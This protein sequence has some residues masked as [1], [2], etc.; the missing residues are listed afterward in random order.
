MMAALFALFWCCC[1]WSWKWPGVEKY[2]TKCPM[3]FF[4]YVESHFAEDRRRTTSHDDRPSLARSSLI[5]CLLLLLS[6]DS[7]VQQGEEYLWW[8]RRAHVWL[9]SDSGKNV[10]R[11]EDHF[12]RHVQSPSVRSI[13]A[14]ASW[15]L[16]L[17]GSWFTGMSACD[18]PQNAKSKH[19]SPLVAVKDLW[20]E[21]SSL[22]S[23]S[24]STIVPNL[25]ALVKDDRLGPFRIVPLESSDEQDSKSRVKGLPS[26]RIS[27][28]HPWRQ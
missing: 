5:L 3:T 19:P 2:L 7:P 17:V 28:R 1:C 22:T 23:H 9:R 26:I 24:P 21:P 25:H 18:P 4:H 8:F 6:R 11:M 20:I 27:W 14:T 15:T 13:V 16:T 12:V 10:S